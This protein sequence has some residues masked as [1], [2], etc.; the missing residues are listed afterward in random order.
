M[1]GEKHGAPDLAKSADSPRLR[2]QFALAD[3]DAGGGKHGEDGG[4]GMEDHAARRRPY[5][6]SAARACDVLVF[7]RSISP[8][9]KLRSCAM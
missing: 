9:V 7:S 1:F 5:I 8:S 6:A 4:N 2:P 3:D